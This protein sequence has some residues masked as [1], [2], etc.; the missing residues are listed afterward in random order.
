[1]RSKVIKILEEVLE[2]KIGKD[3]STDNISAWDSLNQI[4]IILEIED[5]FNLKVNFDDISELTSVD[6]IVSYLKKN[7]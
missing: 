2:M 4:R 5:V 3:A 1:M 7:I 6:T